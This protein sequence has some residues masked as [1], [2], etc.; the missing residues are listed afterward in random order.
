MVWMD[1]LLSPTRLKSRRWPGCVVYSLG[2]SSKL[3]WRQQNSAPC[4]CCLWS[5][6][7]CCLTAKAALSNERLRLFLA[8]W[9]PPSSK[10][11][12]ENLPLVKSFS[13]F[14]ALS[15]GKAQSLVSAQLIRSASPG[16]VTWAIQHNLITWVTACFTQSPSHLK[17]MRIYKGMGSW[18]S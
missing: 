17:G 7:P 15:L 10:P 14:K 11:A 9:P 2:S 16:K 5:P 12:P 1:F 8:T 18:G 6:F 13:H 4:G 3:T